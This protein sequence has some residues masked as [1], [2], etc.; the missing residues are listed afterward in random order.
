MVTTNDDFFF[1]VFADYFY[2]R[3]GTLKVFTESDLYHENTKLYNK[4][5]TVLILWRIF[6]FEALSARNALVN[7][8]ILR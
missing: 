8:C 2:M 5:L 3:V 4:I 1:F 6:N 7:S